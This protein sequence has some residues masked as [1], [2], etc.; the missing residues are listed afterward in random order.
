MFISMNMSTVWLTDEFSIVFEKHW[1]SEA[2]K[3]N[4]T[5]V[6]FPVTVLRYSVFRLCTVKMKEPNMF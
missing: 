5:L 3:N 1:R 2:Q 6:G 4:K